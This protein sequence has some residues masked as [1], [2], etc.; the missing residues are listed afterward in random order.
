MNLKI[1]KLKKFKVRNYMGQGVWY[2][3]NFYENGLLEIELFNNKEEWNKAS[4]ERI[5]G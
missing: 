2:C 5:H 1:F 3:L 4:G